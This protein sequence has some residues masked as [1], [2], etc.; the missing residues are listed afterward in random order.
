MATAPSRRMA[1]VNYLCV[2]IG[3]GTGG[4]GQQTLLKLQ[5]LPNDSPLNI[6]KYVLENLWILLAVLPNS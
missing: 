4:S 5:L 2:T 6:W 3:S 1:L